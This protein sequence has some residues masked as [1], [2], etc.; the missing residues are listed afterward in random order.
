MS[1]IRKQSLISSVVVYI[2]FA[3]GFLNTYLFTK[4]GG[5]TKPE[6][7]LT[8]IFIA[9]AT[10]MYGIAN[11][12]APPYIY[13]F[14]P[15][16]K[17]NLPRKQNDQL[18]IALLVS[19]AGFTLITI[20]GLVFKDL[21]IRK[22]GSN[23]PDFVKYYYYIFPFGL[24]LTLFTVLEGYAWQSRRSIMTNFLREVQFRLLTTLLI[25]LTFAGLITNFGVF[26][27][28]FSFT[29]LALFFFLLI[30]LWAKGEIH[31][32]L[33]ISRVTKK[34]FKKIITFVSFLYT[35]SVVFI[36]S[37]SFDTIVIASTLKDGLAKVAI[38]TLAQNV[39]S[40]IQAPQRGI[41]SA[42]LASL[43]RAWKDKD[44]K[45]INR[46]YHSSSINQLIFSI[47]MFCLIWLNFTDGIFTFHLQSGYV[48]A[49]WVFFYIGIMRI[50]DMGTGVNAQIIGTSSLWKFDFF[51]G[52]ILLFITLPLNYILTKY[53][54]DVQGPAI[55]NLI[56]FTIYNS[57]R[58]LVL[59]R[60][61]KMQPFTAKT[62]Y[63]I[64]LGLACY[65]S[66]YFL[67]HKMQGF[68]P[69]V[70]R[71]SA[72]VLLYGS[73]VVWLRLSPDLL[74]MWQTLKKKM[75]IKKEDR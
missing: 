32:T 54:F 58:Y 16:Y 53:Y 8:G 65:Y 17:D 15:Y 25:L 26:I 9:I 56:S 42:S 70:L 67:F 57:I 14:Y 49:R 35:G 51:T 10:M 38:Y 75:G 52:I 40:L 71:S 1:Q 74:P 29:Y 61:Y 13:K 30:Y 22:F 12:G 62:F 5:F 34:F 24:G 28:L 60:K 45:K 6:Y 4:E 63:C 7:G 31:F 68:W 69:I 48:D 20:A 18:T 72:F 66:C 50:I 3:I 27:K 55:A 36:V 47:G 21:V 44:I 39:A 43:S 11:L 46:I 33:S 19:L 59:L 2:G 37:Q 64:V 23:S 73:V 41:I